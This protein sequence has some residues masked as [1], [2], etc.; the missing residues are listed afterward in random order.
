MQDKPV[1]LR[2]SSVI[3]QGL[4]S[5]DKPSDC[6]PS[7]TFKAANPVHFHQRKC[8]ESRECSGEGGRTEKYCQTGLH[9]MATIP[10]GQ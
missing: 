1:L 7:P 4:W 9:F 5:P 2:G 10:G 8:E 6:L 3:A